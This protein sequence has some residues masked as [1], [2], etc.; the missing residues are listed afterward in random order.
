MEGIVKYKE[1]ELDYLG[2][3]QIIQIAKNAKVRKFV[4][5]EACYKEKLKDVAG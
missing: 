4:V 5:G 3:S 2:G 1:P